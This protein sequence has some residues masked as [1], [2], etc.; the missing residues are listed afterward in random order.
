[1][2]P[3]ANCSL[4]ERGCH[5]DDPPFA[6]QCEA[7]VKWKTEILLYIAEQKLNHRKE[8]KNAHSK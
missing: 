5:D 7:W 8:A 4:N 2:N 3:C 1:M 6:N